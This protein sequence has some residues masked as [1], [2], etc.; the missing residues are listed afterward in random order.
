MICVN[1]SIVRATGP[2]GEAME[3]LGGGMEGLVIPSR[4][5]HILRFEVE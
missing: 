4:G 5:G 2:E 1:F 3:E